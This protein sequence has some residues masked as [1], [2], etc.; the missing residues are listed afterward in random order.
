MIFQESKILMCGSCSSF[1]K[2]TKLVVFCVGWFGWVFFVWLGFFFIAFEYLHQ[3][4]PLFSEQ[5]TQHV[6]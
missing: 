2:A 3:L 5:F 4:L 6:I 1:R